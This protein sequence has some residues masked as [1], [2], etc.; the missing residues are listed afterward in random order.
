MG[1]TFKLKTDNIDH[2]YPAWRKN[3]P[4]T[5]KPKIGPMGQAGSQGI[6]GPMGHQGM[7]SYDSAQ[8]IQANDYVQGIQRN[9][10]VANAAVIESI[11]LDILEKHG[12]MD[13]VHT[14]QDKLIRIDSLPKTFTVDEIIKIIDSMSIEINLNHRGGIFDSS[15]QELIDK[16]KLKEIIKN[17]I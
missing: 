16:N 3:K 8:G 10:V 9:D 12:I 6:P 4:K 13:L 14:K 11:V 1:Y 5:E 2:G 17:R 7:V 15:K